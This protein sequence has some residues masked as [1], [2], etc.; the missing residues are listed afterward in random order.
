VND[1]GTE[2]PEQPEKKRKIIVDEDWKVQ[3]E[4]EKEKL[5]EREKGAPAPAG[6]A[7]GPRSQGRELPPASFATL[8]SSLVTQILFSLGA[9]QDPQTRRRF[10]DLALAKHHIDTLALL[11]EKTKG[12]LTDEEKGIL[13]NA[14]YEVRMAYVQAAQGGA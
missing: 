5:A 7:P 11:E 1:M 14:L 4:A 2:Q 12:N 3:A 8:V 9:V 6:G 13:D 10:R